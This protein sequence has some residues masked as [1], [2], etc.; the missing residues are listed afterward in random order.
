MDPLFT[1]TAW[2]YEGSRIGPLVPGK[3][4]QKQ[5]EALNHPSLHRWLFWGNQTGKTT[6]G[7][8]DVALSCLGRHPLQLAGL[9]HMPPW[10][11]WAS[12]LSWELW[13]KILLPELLTWIP[14]DRII[15]SPLP[16]V[17]STKRDIVVRADNGTESRIT[18]KAAEQGPAKY[19]SARVDEVWL[20]EEHPKAIWDEMQ[21]RL[22]RYN[23]RTVATM[24]P[25]LGLT[26]VYG[27][28][29]EPAKRGAIPPERHWF[30]HAGIKDNPAIS[31][32]SLEELR[33]ELK[34]N[35]SQL[36]AREEGHFVKPIGAVLPFDIDKQGVE[37]EGEDLKAFIRRSRHYGQVDFGKWRF[38]FAWG[39]VEKFG[40]DEGAITMVDEVFSQQEDVE[41]RAKKM[42]DQLQH[43]GIKDIDIYGDCADPDGLLK[44]NQ[45]LA[46]L[47]SPYHVIPV[48][49]ENKRIGAG[50]MRVESLMNR[51]AF[52]VR[53]GMGRDSMWFQGMSASSHGRPVQGSRWIWEA[54]NWQYP[55]GIDGKVQK[56]AP[57]DATADGADMMDGTR[58]LVMEWLGPV[59]EIKAPR[60]D[61][62]LE[63]LKKELD[64]LD[65]GPADESRYGTILRQ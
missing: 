20:D 47:E 8:V 32:A 41:V 52:K 10:T 40:D 42:H 36:A 43:Y 25:I 54:T 53:R 28:V 34:N 30:S 17:H 44:L 21:P 23:G 16:H 27:E 6:F 26:W 4:H 19:Q 13:E 46:N 3:L 50:V 35:P 9:L 1:D 45:A 39:G 12:A 65:E 62:L 14:R 15:D 64:E 59:E 18:G 61:T 63:R 57:D 37:L 22:M 60:A 48:Q 38:A 49:G 29:Y 55:K 31:A 24:T 5:I 7:A 33:A 58:Y 51:G 11:A 56:E 2:E